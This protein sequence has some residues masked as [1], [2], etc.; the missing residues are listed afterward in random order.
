MPDS[1][2]A[3]TYKLLFIDDHPVYG[4]GLAF[5][6]RKR[7]PSLSVET[8][9]N[10][11]S[12]LQAMEQQDYDLVLCDYRLDG[13]NGLQVIAQISQRFPSV[14][15]GLL[16][17]E[18][19]P[20][21]VQRAIAMGAIACLSK[22]RDMDSLADALQQLLAGETVFDDAPPQREQYGISDHRV[23]ILRMASCGLSNKHIANELG[24]SERTVKDHW[25]V[26]FERLRANNRIEAI[27][28]AQSI[29]LIELVTPDGIAR[30]R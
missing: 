27:Q 4:E 5:A 15:L 13:A 7:L 21:L 22:R 6:L 25:Q 23:S 2:R 12:A 26:I 24:I 19:T 16:C 17:A 8:F 29:G 3:A 18:V 28:A 10:E 11:Q 1:P 30:A 20:L 9:C 14:A